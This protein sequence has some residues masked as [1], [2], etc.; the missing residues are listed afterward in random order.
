MAQKPRS[1]G[2]LEFE[3]S[4]VNLMRVSHDIFDIHT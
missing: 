3:L 1:I 2:I 4:M